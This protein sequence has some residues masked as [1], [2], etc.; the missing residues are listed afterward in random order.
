MRS[1]CIASLAVLLLAGCGSRGPT[2]E[3]EPDDAAPVDL[4]ET[5]PSDLEPFLKNRTRDYPLYPGDVIS[6]AIQEHP[7]LSIER[8]IPTDG[9]V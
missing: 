2:L 8:R 9:K 1:I 7:E 3:E 6:V 4:E 5:T